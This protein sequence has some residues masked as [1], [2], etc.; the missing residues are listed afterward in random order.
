MYELG[1]GILPNSLCVPLTPTAH[2]QALYF[3]PVLCGHYFCDRAYQVS[4]DRYDNPLLLFIRSGVLR[5]QYGGRKYR[6]EKGDIVL[7]DCDQPHCYTAEEAVEFLYLHFDGIGAHALAHAIAEESPLLRREENIAIGEQLFDMVQAYRR[8]G[9]ETEA[10]DSLRIY[11]ILMQL[12]MPPRSLVQ[13]DS[14]ITKTVIYIREHVGET[15]PLQ[16]LADMAHLSTFHYSHEFKR[17]TGFSP[18]EY[19]INTRLE[20]AKM[21]LLQTT[22]PVSDIAYAVGYESGSSLSNLFLKKVGCPPREYRK[23]SGLSVK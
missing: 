8:R 13:Q 4:R 20:K 6:A 10:L 11:Q 12:A 16:E 18:S 21:L 7:L 3:Y 19:I 14:P 5:V 9:I 2:A 22:M 23:N 1:P 17:Q 15:I